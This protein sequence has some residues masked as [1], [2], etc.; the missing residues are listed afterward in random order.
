VNEH[1]LDLNRCREILGEAVVILSA[2]EDW[3]FANLIADALKI[4]DRA[5]TEFLT[6][7]ELWGGSGSIVDSG[8]SCEAAP[9]VQ[10]G[11]FGRLIVT[12]G[13]IQIEAGVT[14]V[15]TAMW[16]EAFSKWLHSDI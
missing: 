15:R 7:N 16:V 14:N 6:S 8:L 12:L 4:S 13:T 2:A 5:L 11:A 9:E 1:E 3:H 10:R